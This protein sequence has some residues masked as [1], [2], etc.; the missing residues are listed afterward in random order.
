MQLQTALNSL[1]YEQSLEASILNLQ[2]QVADLEAQLVRAQ[3]L[4]TLGTMSGAIA[5]EFNNILTPLLSYAGLALADLGNTDLVRKALEKSVQSA[6][7]ASQIAD[8]LLGSGVS[9]EHH[10]T[11][12]SLRETIEAA[13]ASTVRPPSSDGIEVL[14]D[15]REDF[16]VAMHPAS[17]HQ[18][19]LNLILNACDA[20]RPGPGTLAFAASMQISPEIQIFGQVA[21]KNR[22]NIQ[23][24]SVL[25]RVVDTGPGMPAE[26]LA[27]VF[28][29][30]VSTKTAPSRGQRGGSGL[31]LTICR[32]LLEQVGGSISVRSEHGLGTSF[33]LQ[34]PLDSQPARA[35]A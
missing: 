19:L 30:L 32:M 5:H 3:R 14:I 17:L 29:P 7:R 4:A 11:G 2:T 20:M 13:L 26:L 16:R 25:L 10:G 18:V 33:T 27:R 31:G 22:S 24:N 15:V 9:Q 8:A 23:S 34:L 6:E 35:A 21:N 1:E 28:D 12:C